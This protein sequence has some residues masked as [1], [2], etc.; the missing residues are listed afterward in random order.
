MGKERKT[1]LSVE[2]LY[3]NART[4]GYPED[5]CCCCRCDCSDYGCF[6]VE[7]LEIAF[8]SGSEEEMNEAKEALMG[9]LSAEI[10]EIVAIS[11]KTLLRKTSRDNVD[12]D[13][14][15]TLAEFENDPKNAEVI[16]ILKEFEE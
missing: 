11:F 10:K 12:M 5:A 16:A 8:N 7:E 9:L 2:E 14:I 13:L 15:R 1:S 4:K 3:E 6:Y